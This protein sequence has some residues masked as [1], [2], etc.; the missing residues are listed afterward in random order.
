MTSRK[1]LREEESGLVSK[2]PNFALI[3][4]LLYPYML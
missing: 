3:L 4:K 2:N 1:Q